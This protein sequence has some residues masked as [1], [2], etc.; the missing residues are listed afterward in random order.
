[1]FNFIITQDPDPALYIIDQSKSISRRGNPRIVH[2]RRALIFGCWFPLAVKNS[3]GDFS[4]QGKNAT[5]KSKSVR[6]EVQPRFGVMKDLP[7]LARPASVT[8]LETEPS[9][10]CSCFGPGAPG[11]RRPI[12]T[13]RPHGPDGAAEKK[14]RFSPSIVPTASQ[15]VGSPTT[16]VSSKEVKVRILILLSPSSREIKKETI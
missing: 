6:L 15:V 3:L 12:F 11:A 14:Q 8:G 5:K 10:H 4:S 7:S 13:L 2:R 16:A 1:M 9:L